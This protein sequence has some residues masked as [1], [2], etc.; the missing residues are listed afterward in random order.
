M[1]SPPPQSDPRKAAPN[2]SAALRLLDLESPP[3]PE[4]PRIALRLRPRP[5]TRARRPRVLA[6]LAVAATA[7][8]VT[9]M[10]WSATRFPET[11][12]AARRSM[13][14]VDPASAAL[15]ANLIVR[16]QQLE[17][18]LRAQDAAAVAVRAEFAMAA[19]EVEALIA[20][21]DARLE[22]DPDP[23]NAEVLWRVRLDLLQEL[24][25]LRSDGDLILTADAS[26]V[27]AVADAEPIN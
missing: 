3:R 23:R 12:D 24:S 11:G 14:A 26:G 20:A 5:P 7:A 27:F 4:W 13:P 22:R 17:A 9:L 10:P 15:V 2:A 21:V 18:A 19:R 8:A 25:T 6:W 1:H 16:N